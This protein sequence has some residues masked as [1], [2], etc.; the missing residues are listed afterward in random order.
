MANKKNP[1]AASKKHR[2]NFLLESIENRLLIRFIIISVC[3]V[4]KFLSDTRVQKAN[5]K[6]KL[7]A[8]ILQGFGSCEFFFLL[9]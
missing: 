1:S 3:Y 7:L 5:L 6:F 2:K 4:T 8:L 9:N